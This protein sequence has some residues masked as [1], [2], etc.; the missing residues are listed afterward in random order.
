MALIEK[1]EGA[2]DAADVD[3]LPETVEDEDVVAQDRFHWIPF[4]RGE[5]P[6]QMERVCV[7]LGK[8]VSK[9]VNNCQCRERY[10]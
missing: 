8:L 4:V 5:K 2:L 9:A 3:R 10:V 6:R 7:T 1:H